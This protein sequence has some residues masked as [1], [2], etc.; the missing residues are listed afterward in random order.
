VVLR[1]RSC[2]RAIDPVHL[3][4]STSL[5]WQ[6]LNHAVA[7]RVLASNL[8][9]AT[10]TTTSTKTS[11]DGREPLPGNLEAWN[12]LRTISFVG[13]SAVAAGDG[14][15]Q[16]GSRGGRYLVYRPGWTVNEIPSTPW[17]HIGS[18]FYG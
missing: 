17:A 8:A 7:A 2:C 16:P 1:R 9:A 11:I 15:V 5:H 14:A 6:A 10:A 3:G 13:E 4:A 12:M 18:G